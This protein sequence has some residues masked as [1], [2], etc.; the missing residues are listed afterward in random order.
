M[1]DKP[2]R[3]PKSLDH[4]TTERRTRMRQAKS[5]M[6]ARGIQLSKPDLKKKKKS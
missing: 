4:I 6:R 2:K 3:K 1:A 5:D